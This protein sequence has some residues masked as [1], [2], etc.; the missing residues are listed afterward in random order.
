MIRRICV[1]T[2]NLIVATLQSWSVGAGTVLLVLLVEIGGSTAVATDSAGTPMQTQTGA[3]STTLDIQEIPGVISY[4]T[5]GTIRGTLRTANGTPVA[6]EQVRLEV[7]NRTRLVETDGNGSFTFQHR[8]QS[9]RT[10]NTDVSI[11]YIPD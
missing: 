6:N 9:A 4:T 1:R 2:V 7:E 3:V 11:R 5:P 10:G 8:P